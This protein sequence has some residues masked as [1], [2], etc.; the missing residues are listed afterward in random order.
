VPDFRKDRESTRNDETEAQDA[1]R[2][3]RSH[4]APLRFQSNTSQVTNLCYI[5]LFIPPKRDTSHF[6]ERQDK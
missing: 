5:A 6:G 2:V 3:Q 4:E 1:L